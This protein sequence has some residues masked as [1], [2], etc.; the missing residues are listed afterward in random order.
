MNKN[1]LDLYELYHPMQFQ[2]EYWYK[3]NELDDTNNNKSLTSSCRRPRK[4]NSKIRNRRYKKALIKRFYM[5]TS[6][7]G[8]YSLSAY[9]YFCPN[10]ETRPHVIKIIHGPF[11]FCDWAGPAWA[12][13]R[14]KTTNR[15]IRK[16]TC[17]DIPLGK[18]SSSHYY[19]FGHF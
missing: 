19:A 11:L 6:T 14:K 5:N 16:M 15:M 18:M 7:N 10:P 1:W 4:I 9:S 8:Y 13:E 17:E 2:P 3:A 12:K